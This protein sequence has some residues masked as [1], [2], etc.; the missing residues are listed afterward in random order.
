MGPSQ[1]SALWAVEEGQG[2]RH[3]HAFLCL[4]ITPGQIMVGISLYIC[5][6]QTGI[7]EKSRR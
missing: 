4:N 3:R 6:D 1:T 7:F 5:Y 2:L